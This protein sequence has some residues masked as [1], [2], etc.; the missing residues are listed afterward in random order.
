MPIDFAPVVVMACV[1]PVALTVA[2]VSVAL[3]VTRQYSVPLASSVVTLPVT[4]VLPT[5]LVL[6]LVS[7]GA[8][9]SPPADGANDT[10]IAP[11]PPAACVKISGAAAAGVI[12]APESNTPPTR[13]DALLVVPAPA[14]RAPAVPSTDITAH[15]LSVRVVTVVVSVVPL[16][17][18]VFVTDASG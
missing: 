7:V 10:D 2:A 11:I 4:V 18:P 15:A 12:A 14:A 6:G 16:A 1:V 8:V 13:L 3:I 17:D 5:A 9:V